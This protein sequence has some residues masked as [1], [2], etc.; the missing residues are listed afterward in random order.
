MNVLFRK[1][2]I[3]SRKK[4]RKKREI[5]SHRYTTPTRRNKPTKG[6]LYQT[7]TF[8][9]FLYRYILVEQRRGVRRIRISFTNLSSSTRI[10]YHTAIVI[11]VGN[12]ADIVPTIISSPIR[13]DCSRPSSFPGHDGVPRFFRNRERGRATLPLSKHSQ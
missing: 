13:Q 4:E 1:N 9:D 11:S 10:E 2:R 7:Q 8:L 3:H 5:A 12:T 6:I